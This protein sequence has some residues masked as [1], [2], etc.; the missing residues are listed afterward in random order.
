MLR[1]HRYDPQ[2]SKFDDALV[3]SCVVWFKNEASPENYDV[4]LSFGGTHEEPDVVKKIDKITLQSR[5][6]WTVL[7]QNKSNYQGESEPVLGDFF[8]IKRGLA[9]GDNNFF[10]LSKKQIEALGLESEFFV[11]ILPSPRFLKDNEIF[12]FGS[13]PEGRHGAGTAKIAKEK[14]GAVYGVGRG[15]TGQCWAL[16]TK[17]LK[18]N[19]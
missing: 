2:N 17:N 12:V 10:I 7:V 6:K 18:P 3:S 4:E 9:T 13:N 16:P 1:I 11:P 15:L 19:F 14:F 5:R 8:R